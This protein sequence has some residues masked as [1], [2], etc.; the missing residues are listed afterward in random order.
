MS[1]AILSATPSDYPAIHQLNEA[2]TPEVSSLTLEKLSELA[3]M[4]FDFS[5]VRD[6]QGLLAFLMLM[7]PGQPYRSENYCWFS[8]RYPVFV[9]VDRIV[10]TE[11]AK[12]KG[13]GRALY[14]HAE[15]LARELAPVLAC[16][17]NLDPPNPESMTF[18][19][20]LGFVEVGQQNT[21][22]GKKRVSLQ[23][24]QLAVLL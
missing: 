12:G 10:V 15:R 13:I 5:L 19:R 6:D 16:E 22:Q 21:E 20:K 23:I 3:V 7:L 24:K 11:R 14:A 8:E 2:S 18:H 9:Y 1:I 4:C 17:I